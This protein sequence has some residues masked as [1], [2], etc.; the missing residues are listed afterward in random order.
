M[1]RMTTEDRLQ[2]IGDN[3]A[4]LLERSEQHAAQLSSLFRKMDERHAGGCALHSDIVRRVGLLEARPG[5]TLK[6]AGIVA[7][8][9]S[10]VAAWINYVVKHQ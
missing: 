8:I 10:A 7:A 9:V 3:V 1:K 5:N 6:A 2:Q 4:K